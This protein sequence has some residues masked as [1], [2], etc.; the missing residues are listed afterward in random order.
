M[1]S[2]AE[3]SSWFTYKESRFVVSP[4]ASQV[5][6]PDPSRVAV[7]WSCNLMGSVFLTIDQLSVASE[8]IQIPL[9]VLPY[10]WLFKDLGGIVQGAVWAH[11]T[12]GAVLHVV[13]VLYRPPY[14]TVPPDESVSPDQVIEE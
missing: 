10:H 7:I 6:K 1:A 12:G 8:G 13:E 14:V 11:G 9:A 5:L 2:I 4:T 3:Q